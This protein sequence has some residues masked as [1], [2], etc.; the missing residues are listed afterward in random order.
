M[1]RRSVLLA[2]SAAAA[3]PFSFVSAHAAG[4]F[5]DPAEKLVSVTAGR[6]RTTRF[7][8]D[9]L[10]A[11]PQTRFETKAPWIATPA[12]F[13]GPS[14]AQLLRAF[15]P[16]AAFERAEIA[17]LDEYAATADVSRLV[18]DDAIFAIRQ[19]GAFM[20]VADKG[21]ALLIFPFD[22]RPELK[23]KPHFGLCIWQISR[24]RLS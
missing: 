13:E 18:A 23:D 12:V 21:P 9:D 19:N 17:A 14:V 11:L 5:D 22:D 15:A 3:H 7:S 20:S 16:E 2:I 24:I 10:A 8:R 1:S 4:D 6:G